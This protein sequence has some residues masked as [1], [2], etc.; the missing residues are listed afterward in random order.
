VVRSLSMAVVVFPAKRLR[1]DDEEWRG[2]DMRG[3]LKRWMVER[4]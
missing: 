1:I 2:C 3:T 4:E